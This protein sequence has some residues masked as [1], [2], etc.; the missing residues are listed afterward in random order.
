MNEKI[1][2]NFISKIQTTHQLIHQKMIFS[3]LCNFFKNSKNKN[4]LVVR[5]INEVL[6]EIRYI[7]KFNNFQFSDKSVK[8]F[9]ISSYLY[10]LDQT[11]ESLLS[12]LTK[13]KIIP[14]NLEEKFKNSEYVKLIMIIRNTLHHPFEIRISNEELTMIYNSKNINFQFNNKKLIKKLIDLNF[15]D[16][17]YKFSLSYY[18]PNIPNTITQFFNNDKDMIYL[19]SFDMLNNDDINSISI[20]FDFDLILKNYFLF[21]IE[22]LNEIEKEIKIFSKELGNKFNL[23]IK[24]VSKLKNSKD[25]ILKLENLLFDKESNMFRNNEDMSVETTFIAKHKL[26]QDFLSSQLN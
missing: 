1:F 19:F 21:L 18:S 6:K 22:I 10:Y 24:S 25:M 17:R 3:Y 4:F 20:G 9:F 13:S 14:K 2:A 23:K 7:G 12:V 5:T 8:S 15:K 11:F 26:L 16:K